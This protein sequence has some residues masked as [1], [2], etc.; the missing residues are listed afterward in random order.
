M[1]SIDLASPPRFPRK[2]TSAPRPKSRSPS[3]NELESDSGRLVLRIHDKDNDANKIEGRMATKA[4][5]MMTPDMLETLGLTPVDENFVSRREYQDSDSSDRAGSDTFI[6]V[7]VPTRSRSALR[8][9]NQQVSPPKKNKMF[10]RRAA[11]KKKNVSF[12]FNDTASC[13]YYADDDDTMTKTSMASTC[14]TSSSSSQSQESKETCDCMTQDSCP[15][16]D[17]WTYENADD[18][19]HSYVSFRRDGSS[20]IDCDPMS[21]PGMILTMPAAFG[22]LFVDNILNTNYVDAA[23][24]E[25]PKPTNPYS[26]KKRKTKH[27]SRRDDSRDSVCGHRFLPASFEPCLV[28]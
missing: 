18:E 19:S 8:S 10:E 4:E 25:I 1:V 21:L 17:D 7:P 11:K 24:G 22:L 16:R 14:T 26:M 2:E 5:S 27:F 13:L 15:V 20:P 28:L 23:I 12:K 9:R 6:P 3:K